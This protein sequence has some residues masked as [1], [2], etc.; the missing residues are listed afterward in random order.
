MRVA[1]LGDAYAESKD[2]AL[3]TI[4]AAGPDAWAT[5]VPAAPD[6]T[7]VDVVAHVTGL[8]ADGAAGRLPA[9]VN[10]L[11]Q[12][13]DDDVVA[14]RDAFADGQVLR[15]RGLE[16]HA[17]VAEWDDAEVGLVERLSLEAGAPGALPFGFD[18]VLVTDLCVHADDI[19]GALR[20]PPARTSAATAIA[21]AGY[22][23]GLA[24]RLDALELPALTMVY[25]GKERTVGGGEAGAT[26]RADRWELLRVLAGRRSRDQILD[27]DWSG[28]PTPYLPLLPAYG[29]RSEPLVEG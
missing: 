7:V 4:A 28:D 5:P 21:L 8:A 12:F 23:F 1:S 17:I 26:V 25:G 15:R 22:S 18:I 16:P 3:R 9:D 20:Q 24:Y 11:E 13:R 14:A 27:L 10:L 6:W 29:E 2:F 19:A